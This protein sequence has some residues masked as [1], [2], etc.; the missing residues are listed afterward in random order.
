MTF[1]SSYKIHP[2]SSRQNGVLKIQNENRGIRIKKIFF[3]FLLW[4]NHNHNNNKKNEILGKR[5]TGTGMIPTPPCSIMSPQRVDKNISFSDPHTTLK[6]FIKTFKHW[7][8]IT[9]N[10]NSL[11][12]MQINVCK[13]KCKRQNWTCMQ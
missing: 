5:E 9:N 12:K 1:Y 4:S 7:N 2:S 11:T 13:I 8:A 10:H 3:L 6:H